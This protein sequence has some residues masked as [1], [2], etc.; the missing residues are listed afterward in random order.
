MMKDEDIDFVEVMRLIHIEGFSEKRVA[1]L[2]DKILNDGMWT[3]PVAIDHQ[4][5]LVLD[6]QHRLE[7]AKILGLN[8]IP[9]V[10]Y[11]YASV[12]TWSLRPD[13]HPLSIDDVVGRALA[14][15][16]YPYKTVKH[17]FDPALPSCEIP[18]EVLRG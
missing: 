10:R 16:P 8:K 13:T 15:N 12:E 11:V 7:A 6:G 2:V 9:A 1:W 18:L 17:A 5:H 4:H 14:N 3:L